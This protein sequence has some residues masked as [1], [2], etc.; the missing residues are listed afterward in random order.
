M[1][2]STSFLWHDRNNQQIVEHCQLI[3]IMPSVMGGMKKGHENRKKKKDRKMDCQRN[4][5]SDIGRAE[6]DE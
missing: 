4:G 6:G 1:D 3:K 2:H 5:E